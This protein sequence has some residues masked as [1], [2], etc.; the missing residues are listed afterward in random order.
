MGYPVVLSELRGR[1]SVGARPSQMLKRYAARWARPRIPPTD[2]G[3]LLR[4]RLLLRGKGHLADG[5]S[6]GSRQDRHNAD[7]PRP[8]GRGSGGG[9]QVLSP[10]GGAVG[11]SLYRRCLLPPLAPHSSSTQSTRIPDRRR[12][13]CLSGKHVAAEGDYHEEI[14]RSANRRNGSR[15][16]CRR[17]HLH[18]LRGL[19]RRPET[20]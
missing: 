8:R 17:S 1:P 5:G 6:A 16:S 7:L 15:P 11:Q 18:G 3:R 9:P 14:N 4:H 2:T 19:L 13:P 20:G 10:N 12:L